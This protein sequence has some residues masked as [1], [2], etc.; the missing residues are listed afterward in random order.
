MTDHRPDDPLTYP[1]GRR[2]DHAE[3]VE[4]A[5]GVQWIR[6]QIPIPGLD[7]INL[8]LIEDG[9][10]W[11]IVDTGLRSKK[12]Q[13]WW[14][15]I[16]A[17]YLGGKPVTRV[18][19]THFHPDHMGLAG[20][21]V[22][23][24]PGAVLWMSFG[25]WSFGRMLWLDTQEEMPEEVVRFYRRLGWG[26]QALAAFRKRGYNFYS[27]VVYDVPHGVRR[28]VDGESFQIGG[29]AWRVI[30]GQ[31]HSPEHACL[32][33][34]EL[35]LLIS[36]DQILP[37]ITPHI[38]IYPS[39]PDGNPL[40]LYIDSIDI[41]RPLPADTLVLPAHGDPFRGL[42]LRLDAL[43]H[44]HDVRLERLYVACDK[45]QTA[46]EVVPAMFSR[47]L[48]PDDMR[49]ASAEGVAHLHCLMGMGRVVREMASDGVYR[50]RRAA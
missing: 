49:L 33:C 35:G 1:V 20:W 48:K 4:V 3:C 7:F 11:T 38:G 12:T 40:Q 46:L 5:P 37:R 50:Y 6:M 32:Y 36:G 22:E 34:A 41:F 28:I 15:E 26:E 47:K 25:E 45:P 27:Q 16:F 21:L 44:H 13:A 18:I 10:G 24:F 31:G 30:V 23:R 39:E 2:P 42:P 9:D 8:W 43:A 29:R 19:C 17:K 14:E